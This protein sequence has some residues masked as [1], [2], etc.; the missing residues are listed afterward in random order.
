ML[1][2]FGYRI[3]DP[4]DLTFQF[5]V[6]ASTGVEITLM[7]SNCIEKPRYTIGLSTNELFGPMLGAYILNEQGLIE[8]SY[9]GPHLINY[10]QLRRFS[11]S[12]RYYTIEVLDEDG[13]KL[14][15]WT[16]VLNAFGIVNIG[17]TNYGKGHWEIHCEGI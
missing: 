1:S 8:D 3:R 12:W 5:A 7:S 15:K 10:D 13:N 2:A 14:L 16:D 17:V 4:F 11:I 9:D 6:N